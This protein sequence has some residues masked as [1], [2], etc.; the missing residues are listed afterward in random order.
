MVRAQPP[1]ALLL[2]NNYPLLEVQ[3][4][5]NDMQHIGA[6]GPSLERCSSM[7][8]GCLLCGAAYNEGG[9]IAHFSDVSQ[10]IDARNAPA[11]GAV[12]FVSFWELRLREIAREGFGLSGKLAIEWETRSCRPDLFLH[13]NP[14]PASGVV[15]VLLDSKFPAVIAIHFPGLKGLGAHG[16]VF[17]T[18]LLRWI[19]GPQQVRYKWQ[20]ARMDRPAS[21]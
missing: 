7:N 6:Y 20:E 3:P 1:T 9:S 4:S 19:L 21:G 8:G 17:P 10:D 5:H 12:C 2:H 18:T 16:G 13:A 14:P 11:S 15:H